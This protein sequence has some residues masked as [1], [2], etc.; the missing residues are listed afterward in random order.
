MST[1]IT[2]RSIT[3]GRIFTRSLLVA[4]IV[5]LAACGGGS[6]SNT[7]AMVPTDTAANPGEPGT[8]LPTPA[9]NPDVGSIPLPV[10]DGSPFSK[11]TLDDFFGRSLESD[12]ETPIAGGPPTRPKNLHVNLLANNW[13][14]L[15][16]AASRDDQSVVAYRIYRGDGVVYTV[17]SSDASTDGETNRTLQNYWET[18]TYI[19]CNFTH[20]ST[21]HMPGRQ[22]AVGSLHTYQVSAVDNLGNE[23]ERSNMIEVKLHSEQGGVIPKFADP[24]LDGD[25]DFQF[26]TDLSNTGNFMDQ[27]ELIWSDEFDS[28]ELDATKWSTSLTWRQEDQNIINGEMQYFVDIQSQPDFGFNPFVLNGE[29]LTISAIRTPA[30]L[31][32]KAL[33]QPFLSGALSTHEVKSGQTG[34]DGQL[35]EDKFATTY[36]YI[37]GRMRVG[38]KSGMLTSFYLFRRWAAEH[39]PEIDIV[40]YL[41]ENPFGD[42]RAF[43]TYHY[44]DVVHQNTLSTPTMSYPRTEGKFGDVKDLDGFHTYSVLWEP[45]L[46]VWYIDGE[47][48]QRLTGPQISRQSMNIILYLVTGSA[49]APQP[50]DNAT[51]PF[52]IEIDYVRAYKRRPWQG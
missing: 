34:P 26:V 30:E 31:L 5:G 17:A 12:S 24:Y 10:A 50:A 44:R 35:I 42:E 37:E 36:G 39:S 21:C 19:D 32:D 45:G 33:G 18:T 51:F 7:P 52:D 13:V 15:D 1:H 14:E 11:A 9:A 6:S 16:W 47:E 40:E 48:I 20:V 27:F 28:P 38:Q 3:S 22:P 25:D 8:G 29:T 4:S 2:R 41:G 23:S 46:V 49:W 43:Q